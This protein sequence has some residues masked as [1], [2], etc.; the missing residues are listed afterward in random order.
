MSDYWNK[1]IARGHLYYRIAHSLVMQYAPSGTL[2]DVGG[3]V[4]LGCRYLEWYPHD[5][6]V[7]D[8]NGGELDNAAVIQSDVT[9][10]D[11][12]HR[13]NVAL[14]LQ[15]LEHL[16]DPSAIAAKLR[17]WAEIVVV[18]VPYKWA[19]DRQGQH[20]HHNLDLG[21]VSDWFGRQP[22]ESV[23]EYGAHKNTSRIIAVFD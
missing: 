7:L 20:E 10:W 5:K 2:L 13:Y 23:I 21:T 17:K 19:A 14:C 4:H 8:V 6:T 11:T 18:S 15:V 1:R 9:H 3:G 16:P 22:I 12:D